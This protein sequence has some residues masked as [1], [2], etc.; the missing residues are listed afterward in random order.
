MVSDNDSNVF[1]FEGK[2]ISFILF[3]F[4][5]FPSRYQKKFVIII[6]KCWSICAEWMENHHHHQLKITNSLS[7]FHNILFYS[8][9]R[10]FFTLYT[11]IFIMLK[12]FLLLF[13]E[14]EKHILLLVWIFFSRICVWNLRLQNFFIHFFAS[15][16][17]NLKKNRIND[18][19]LF[20][21]GCCSAL[22]QKKINQIV[23]KNVWI[24]SVWTRKKR[25]IFFSFLSFFFFDQI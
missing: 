21:F 3:I 10:F 4:V 20:F 7:P 12:W 16:Q 1:Y 18:F 19:F 23:K 17:F 2:K 9:F 25:L 6:N 5:L 24:S 15:F 22:K 14:W 8:L 11:S 13:R